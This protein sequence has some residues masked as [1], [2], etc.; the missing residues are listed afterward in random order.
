MRKGLIFSESWEHVGAM[1]AD[2][3]A[4]EQAAFFKAFIRECD[5]WGTHFQVQSQLATINLRL[6]KHERETISMLGYDEEDPI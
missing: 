2:S 1:L 5:S 3:N 4:D 6:N